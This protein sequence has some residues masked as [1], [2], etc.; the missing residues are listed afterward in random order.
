MKIGIG[1][2]HGGFHLK[3]ELK[4]L[5]EAKGYTYVDYGTS[6]EESVDYP[7]YGK[8][9]C[10]GIIQGDVD[11]GVAICG[12][13]V[14][15]SIACNKVKGI[16]AAHVTDSFTARAV[17]GHNDAQ[18]LCLGERITGVEIA[19]DILINFLEADFEG[20]RHQRRLDKIKAIEEE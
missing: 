5:L 18:V 11:L 1:S 6:S 12:T 16:R 13:G 9:I 10:D 7:D 8:K 20:D 4:A 17:R 14:G 2:D 3:E 19:K 15:M